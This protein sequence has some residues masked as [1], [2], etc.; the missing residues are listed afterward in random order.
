MTSESKDTKLTIRISE[1]DLKEIDEFLTFNSKFGSRS[2]FIRHSVLDYIAKSRVSLE[3]DDNDPLP[4]ER[5]LDEIITD[6]VNQGLFKSKS[7]AIGEILNQAFKTG[8][9]VELFRAKMTSYV[10]LKKELTEFAK[11]RSEGKIGKEVRK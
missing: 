2:E 4:V 3:R 9:I 11:A 5:N 7:E 10:S 8:M 6:A 1:E